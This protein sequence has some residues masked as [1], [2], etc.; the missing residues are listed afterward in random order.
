M[1]RKAH[2][3]QI[4][5]P[6]RVH[7][8][9]SLWNRIAS[10]YKAKI[11]LDRGGKILRVASKSKDDL[12]HLVESCEILIEQL[13]CNSRDSEQSFMKY[14]FVADGLNSSW[15]FKE[16][17]R[18]NDTYTLVSTT[19][20]QLQ[21]AMR[22]IENSEATVEYH[23]K[24][25]FFQDDTWINRAAVLYPFLDDILKHGRPVIEIGLLTFQDLKGNLKSKDLMEWEELRALEDGIGFA[26][27]FDL[28]FQKSHKIIQRIKNYPRCGIE[29][30]CVVKVKNNDKNKVFELWFKKS[31]LMYR[32]VKT[33]VSSDYQEGS[34]GFR[35]K[36]GSS[37]R[38]SSVVA[39]EASE[40]E[41]LEKRVSKYGNGKFQ[42]IDGKYTVQKR[43]HMIVE[44]ICINENVTM[45]VICGMKNK[46]YVRAQLECEG[47]ASDANQDAITL[48]QTVSTLLNS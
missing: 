11:K 41:N 32:L 24:G 38:V 8:R 35:A 47:A 20:K 30:Y 37:Y 33:C 42:I 7:V 46:S 36:E 18:E 29:E 39:V 26:V 17:S 13:S 40:Q 27:K 31:G 48:L 2:K 23:K 1:F 14:L 21:G 15:R 43:E 28:W 10:F 12:D 34:V 45:N 6:R 19:E 16:V 4:E 25:N 5:L 3:K 9:K 44:R 22:E